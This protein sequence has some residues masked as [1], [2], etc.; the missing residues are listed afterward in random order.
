MLLGGVWLLLPLSAA[1]I[2]KTVPAD[3]QCEYPIDPLGID[4]ALPRFSWKLKDPEAVRG[5]K[6]SAYQI[7]VARSEALLEQN[8]GDLWDSGRVSSAQSAL[9]PYAGKKLVSN[10]ST[11]SS[12][13]PA[14]SNGPRMPHSTAG[15]FKS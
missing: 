13:S 5:Q 8:A 1:A 6:Q 4:A 10:Q 2:S 7:L 14:S 12:E 11:I 15:G 9:V 3:P